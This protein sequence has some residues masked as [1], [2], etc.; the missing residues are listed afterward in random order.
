[1]RSGCSNAALSVC[2]R[3]SDPE[4]GRIKALPWI[5]ALYPVHINKASLVVCCFLLAEEWEGRCN[6]T[7]I[8][9]MQ[10]INEG[11]KSWR[12]KKDIQS[13][14]SERSEVDFACVPLYYYYILPDRSRFRAF[15]W[16]AEERDNYNVSIRHH[17]KNKKKSSSEGKMHTDIAGRRVERREAAR[18]NWER[19]EG[20]LHAWLSTETVRRRSCVQLESVYF[21]NLSLPLP[22]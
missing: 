4:M 12:A 5:K 21:Q 6:F 15:C 22:S 13:R 11:R 2:A 20:H 10:L 7:C 1:M 17:W 18:W 3:S 9:C 16:L 19:N 14:Y 8:C